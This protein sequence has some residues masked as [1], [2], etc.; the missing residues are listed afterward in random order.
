MIVGEGPHSIAW[1]AL[2][3]AAEEAA[4]DAGADELWVHQFAREIAGNVNKR[5]QYAN[6]IVGGSIYNDLFFATWGYRPQDFAGVQ[7]RAMILKPVH[8]DVRQALLDGVF[9]QRTLDLG[10]PQEA[11]TGRAITRTRKK[12]PHAKHRPFMWLPLL[13]LRLLWEERQIT[14]R[15]C[16]WPDSSVPCQEPPPEVLRLIGFGV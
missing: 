6:L 10:T 2:Y 13:N 12:F 14:T 7:G 3:A 11:R 9:P 1:R 15:G 16:V 5:I 4:R 8:A